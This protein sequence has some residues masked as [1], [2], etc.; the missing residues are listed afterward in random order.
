MH[1]SVKKQN[2]SQRKVIWQIMQFWGWKR[3]CVGQ[4]SFQLPFTRKMVLV[5]MIFSLLVPNYCSQGCSSWT[6]TILISLTGTLFH[7]KKK[8]GGW[9][10]R[11]WLIQWLFQ[12]IIYNSW[13]KFWQ[14]L[15][16]GWSFT[17]CFVY[18]KHFYSS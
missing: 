7:F 8:K 9:T 6:S 4:I 1:T 16:K 10:F 13:Y 14:I 12:N 15:L 2:Y 11:L 5:T 18:F 3:C 17:R